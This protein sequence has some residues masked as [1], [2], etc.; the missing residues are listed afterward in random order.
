MRK[1]VFFLFIV[2]VLFFS[3]FIFTEDQQTKRE[4][5]AQD[6]FDFSSVE[7]LQLLQ[8][9]PVG[10][11]QARD[12]RV[13]ADKARKAQQ[14]AQRCVLLGPWEEII[15]ARQLKSRLPYEAESMRIVKLVEALPEVFWV[16]LP[17]RESEAKA[18]ELVAKLQSEGIDSFMVGDE[19]DAYLYAI[20]LGVYSKLASAESV[21]ADIVAKGYAAQVAEKM[22]E[23]EQFWLALSPKDSENFKPEAIETV[24]VDMPGLK[25]KEKSCQSIAVLK[26]FE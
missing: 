26:T 5:K 7:R 17:P 4:Q 20:S 2:N 18:R 22:R 8:E 9:L 6:P 1:L 19:Q 15:S 11:L 14:A 10:A 12:R 21:Q 24:I 16:Y 13:L 23:Q 25:N 3:W